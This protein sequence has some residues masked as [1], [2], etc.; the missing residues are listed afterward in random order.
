[1]SSDRRVLAGEVNVALQKDE[2][3]KNS[4]HRNRKPKRRRER[5]ERQESRTMRSGRRRV[6]TPL[7]NCS[8]GS[9]GWSGARRAVK[10][11]SERNSQGRR[12]D[13]GARRLQTKGPKVE[14]DN[15]LS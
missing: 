4:T 12:K 9:G 14:G 5:G 13:R 8:M 11:G 7:G 3:E 2:S 6:S 15:Q 10:D 1:V